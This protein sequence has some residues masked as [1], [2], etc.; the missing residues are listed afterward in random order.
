MSGAAKR[1]SWN[2]QSYRVRLFRFFV[3]MLGLILALTLFLFPRSI[4]GKVLDMSSLKEIAETTI[5]TL[6]PAFG[7]GSNHQIFEFTIS[8]RLS[9]YKKNLPPS[10]KLCLVTTTDYVHTDGSIT[11]DWS[12]AWL[13]WLVIVVLPCVIISSGIVLFVWKASPFKDAK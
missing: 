13:H 8:P 7:Y 5:V 6:S 3:V 10:K 9:T 11:C 4:P 1:S 12:F 2:T